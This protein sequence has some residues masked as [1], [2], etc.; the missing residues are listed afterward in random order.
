MNQDSGGS[1]PTYNYLHSKSF[2][3]PSST[4]L[5]DFWNFQTKFQRIKAKHPPVKYP[6]AKNELGVPVT[7]DTQHTIPFVCI[8]AREDS[9]R[10]KAEQFHECLR[11]YVQFK[12]KQ[13]FSKVVKQLQ[14]QR[15]LPIY[16]FKQEI[17]KTVNANPITIIAGK[18]GSTN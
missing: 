3:K 12:S 9:H 6:I 14:Y 8:S 7:F 10:E 2:L 16:K 18:K 15:E 1:N 5:K 11:H 4:D 17:I 13:S